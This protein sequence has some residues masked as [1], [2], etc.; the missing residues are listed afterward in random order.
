[1]FSIRAK[2][3][4]MRVNH[5]YKLMKLYDDDDKIILHLKELHV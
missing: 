3:F 1:M 2:Q 5:L 4:D